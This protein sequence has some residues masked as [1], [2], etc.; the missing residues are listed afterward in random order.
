RGFRIELGEIETALAAH[1]GI[2][3]ATAIVRTDQPGEKRLIG[4]AVPTEGTTLDPTEIRR[5]LAG[6]LPEYMVPSAVIILDHFPLTSNGKLDRKALPAPDFTTAI[7]DRAPRT[8]REELLCHLF[9]EVLQLPHV[10]IDDNF[11][12]LGG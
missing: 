4:Y 7:G 5:N 11:F 12:D 1:P 8:P 6:S 9:A 3:Q 2:A 10:G